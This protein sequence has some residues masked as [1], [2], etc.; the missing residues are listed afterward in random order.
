M[1]HWKALISLGEG[2]IAMCMVLGRS[3][4]SKL[5]ARFVDARRRALIGGEVSLIELDF[6]NK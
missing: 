4:C 6:D 5:H 3:K 1:C 2:F